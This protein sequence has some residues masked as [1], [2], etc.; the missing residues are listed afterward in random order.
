[1]KKLLILI[2]LLFNVFLVSNASALVIKDIDVVGINAIS[3]S[4]VM[5]Y[6]PINVGDELNSNTSNQII[7]A[8]Y[9]TQL[10]HDI[11]VTESEQIITIT[12][13]ERPHIK[14]VD[15]LNYSNDEVLSDKSVELILKD[16]D[17]SQ[18]K[19]FNKRKLL[20]LTS[21]LEELYISNGYYN[22]KISDSVLIDN[23][24][25]VEIEINIDE[26]EVA[27]I[28]SMKIV[29]SKIH[30]E[31]DLLDMLDIGEPDFWIINYFTEKDNFSRVLLD[32]G[33]SSIQSLYIN[34]GYLD[35]S[36][37]DTKV[38]LSKDN[39]TIDIVIEIS[40]GQLFRLGNI[41]FNGE[42]LNNS[43]EYLVNLLGLS[44]G[45]VFERADL[46]EGI[47]NVTNI[48]KD[49]GYAFVD[50]KPI[51]SI[52]AKENHVDLSVNVT[53]NKKVYINRI[54]ISGNTRTQDDVVR[55]EI[56]ISEGGLYS[57]SELN[58]SVTKIKRLGFFSDVQMLVDN[59][60]E[61]NDKINLH[62]KLVETKTGNFTAGIAH[63]AQTG[64]SFNVGINEK[65]ILGTGNVLNAQLISSKA[66]KEVSFIFQDPYF[67]EQGHN[68]NYGFFNKK[69]D[70]SNLELED[71]KIDQ[72]GASIGYGIPLTET[73][74]LNSKITT[75]II[76]ITCGAAFNS[77][78]YEQSQCASTDKNEV[79]VNM[80][81]SNNTLDNYLYPTVGSRNHVGLDLSIPPGDFKY[82]KLNAGHKSYYPIGNDLTF[83]LKGNI[84][85]AGGYSGKKLPFFKRYFGGGSGSVRGFNF[86]SLGSKYPNGKPKGGEVSLYSSASV[87]SP[88]NFVDNSENMRVSAFI[89]AGSVH[90]NS[91]N[92][93]FDEVRMSVGLAFYWLTPI[94][95]LGI[96]TAE[97]VIKKTG[98]TTKTVQFTIGSSF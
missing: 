77:A 30:T 63:S 82:Y 58:N 14:H 46:I 85:I 70:A 53:L 64:S 60:A 17:L 92:I 3:K 93:D 33:I 96:Y 52:A 22:I 59:T 48:Y 56:G 32:S 55:R 79:K 36:V 6:L 31:D 94:G 2:A 87:I 23:Q 62:F 13:S 44:Q 20:Q 69:L 16:M 21:Q 83:S 15:V 25:R 80:N 34:S 88:I 10:F 5:S 11:E 1:M 47:D 12:V 90:E 37:T 19:I 67:N 8:L 42:L 81:W 50:I 71:Y 39:S 66:V 91:S 27:K 29:G 76:D 9:K 35:F 74:R 73:T 97:P 89:D 95:P 26:G 68:I 28:R 54:T 51:T 49:Q 40:E 7:K 86:N 84:G 57:Q 43:Q 24:N 41:D 78:G 72:T 4:T 75:S 98:D 65:N 61:F 45:D 18:G 38:D